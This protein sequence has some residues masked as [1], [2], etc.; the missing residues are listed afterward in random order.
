MKLKA[1][2]KKFRILDKS[3]IFLLGSLGTSF[4]CHIW[5]LNLN[6][7]SCLCA[8][9]TIVSLRSSFSKTKS[10]GFVTFSAFFSFRSICILVTELDDSGCKPLLVDGTGSFSC[11]PLLVDG[12]GSSSSLGDV[13]VAWKSESFFLTF[14]MSLH[15]PLCFSLT[16]F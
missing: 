11:T 13:E 15:F 12:T 4:K 10:D 16:K 7:F 6:F 1:I 2:S 14:L 3:G 8:A 9:E 5:S